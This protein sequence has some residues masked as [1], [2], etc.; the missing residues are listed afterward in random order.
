MHRWVWETAFGPIP[1][2]MQIMHLC[3]NPP[4]YRLDHLQL[5]TPADNC[6][7]RDGKGRHRVNGGHAGLR[8]EEH[9]GAKVTAVEVAEIR[10]RLSSGSTIS[11]LAAELGMPRSRVESIHG[12]RT[13]RYESAG[14][15]A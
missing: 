1:P 8:G 15:V 12:G 5:G 14:W 2:G 13:W 7:D 11:E 3:D 6:A 4:C 10:R 9:H